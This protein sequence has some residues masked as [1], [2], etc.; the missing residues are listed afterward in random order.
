MERGTLSEERNPDGSE[1]IAACELVRLALPRRVFTLSQV[2]FVADIRTAPA[3]LIPLFTA[4]IPK[5]KET[6]KYP[7]AIGIPSL[8][9]FKNSFFLLFISHSQKTSRYI[10]AYYKANFKHNFSIFKFLVKR[11]I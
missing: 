4:L 8:M 9:P 1:H 2:R 5:A 6:D 11:K 7:S 10:L 3:P